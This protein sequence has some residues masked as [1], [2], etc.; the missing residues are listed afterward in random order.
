MGEDRPRST[1]PALLDMTACR[2][3]SAPRRER[4]SPDLTGQQAG[5]DC[6]RE[7][8]NCHPSTSLPAHHCCAQTG[9][10]EQHEDCAHLPLIPT[11]PRRATTAPRISR[12]KWH[13]TTTIQPSAQRLRSG[14]SGRGV[15]GRTRQRSKSD[16]RHAR[17]RLCGVVATQVHAWNYVSAFSFAR[18][19]SWSVMT[20][21]FLRSSSLAMSSAGDAAASR[22]YWRTAASSARVSLTSCAF[23]LSPRAIR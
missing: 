19:N 10:N 7:D 15:A 4:R 17:R 5:T 11:K 21:R 3:R 9:D 22:T 12:L 1:A 6:Q 18:S 23:I 8:G 16:L 2:S 13:A 14:H 20:P